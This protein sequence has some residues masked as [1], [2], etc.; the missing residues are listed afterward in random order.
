MTRRRKMKWIEIIQFR[1]TREATLD[2]LVDELSRSLEGELVDVTIYRHTTISTDLS[3]HL[4]HETASDVKPDSTLGQ[5]LAATL[6]ELGLVNR[7]LW[8]EVCSPCTSERRSS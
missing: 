1:S 8:S 6:D 5:R 3:I 2:A 7:S 4:V